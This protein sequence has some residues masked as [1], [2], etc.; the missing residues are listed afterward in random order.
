[1]TRA[2]VDDQFRRVR[3]TTAR[4]VL[5]AL[6]LASGAL[7]ACQA[8]PS[9]PPDAGEVALPEGEARAAI[10]QL[11]PV[12][13]NIHPLSRLERGPDPEAPSASASPAL[14][15][16]A[17]LRVA[18]HLELL[19]RFDQ[20]A[21]WLGRATIILRDARGESAHA[22]LT[23]VRDLIDPQANADAFDWVTR[24]YVVACGGLPEWAVEAARR[25][26]LRID[27]AFSVLKADGT[28]QRIEGTLTLPEQK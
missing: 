16:D 13:L 22:P 17:A 1:M 6:A 2:R 8:R 20:G 9:V 11:E 4:G 28:R 3:R 18:V 19:D 12:K 21:K 26:R 27:A 14:A 23:Y 25:G 15:P 10:A 5:G 24:C 7:F